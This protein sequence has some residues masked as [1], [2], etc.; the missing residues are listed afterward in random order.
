MNDEYHH[1]FK[2]FYAVKDPYS[3]PFNK[4]PE[5]TRGTGETSTFVGIPVKHNAHTLT[6]VKLASNGIMSKWFRNIPEG[7]PESFSVNTNQKFYFLNFEK[8][9]M[10]HLVI[11]SASQ[12]AKTLKILLE[13][14]E[15]LKHDDYYTEL[16]DVHFESRNENLVLSNFPSDSQWYQLNQLRI[17]AGCPERSLLGIEKLA[18]YLQYLN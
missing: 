10:P 16:K 8:A 11:N 17:H 5:N 7:S 9:L 13:H 18:K 15:Q 14:E 6:N 1:S 12:T 3:L 4:T 2:E